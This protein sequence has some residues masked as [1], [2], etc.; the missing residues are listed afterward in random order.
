MTVSIAK[1]NVSLTCDGDPVALIPCT[2]AIRVTCDTHPGLDTPHLLEMAMG[3][4]RA[5]GWVETD[6]DIVGRRVLCAAC[7]RK[8][9]GWI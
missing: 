4:A 8:R 3:I 2:E 9:S 7:R 6:C 5:A 1:G